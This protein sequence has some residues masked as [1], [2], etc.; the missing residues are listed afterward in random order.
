[1]S[2]VLE[3]PLTAFT[4]E[5]GREA[6]LRSAEV[7][8]LKAQ[9]LENLRLI[10]ATK[11]IEQKPEP[12]TVQPEVQ[13]QVELANELLAHAHAELKRLTED[14]YGFCETCKRHGADAKEQS[15]LLREIRGLMEHLC[16]LHNIA[17]APTSKLTQARAQPRRALPEP[18]LAQPVEVQPP[19][20]LDKGKPNT[21]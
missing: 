8:R 13:R 18:T 4:A 1:M 15:A 16:R 14:D 19:I 3:A 10:L 11:P 12:I 17:Q 21:P 6:G 2:E 20:E 7:A 5:T 9:E